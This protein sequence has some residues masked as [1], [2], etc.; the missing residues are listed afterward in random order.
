MIQPRLLKKGDTVAIVAPARKISL[1]E[2]QP[3]IDLLKSWGLK[4]VL[5]KTIGLEHHQFAGTDIDRTLDFQS[6]LDDKNIKAIWCARGGYGT[7][8]IIDQLNFTTFIKHPKWVI[9]YSDI[10][11]LHS[12]IHNLGVKTI[13]ATMPINVLK[14]TI[15]SLKSLKNT[16]FY[17]KMIKN[18]PFSKDNKIGEASGVLVGGNLSIL[19]SLIGST[20]A[21]HTKGKILFIEDVDEYLYHIDRMMIALKRSG[22]LENIKGLIIGGMIQ[23]HDN[24]IPFG[25][26]AEE[27]ILDIVSEYDY[28][29][30]F[31]FPSGH[32]DSHISLILGSEIHLSVKLNKTTLKKTN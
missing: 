8:R 29:V 6:M 4:V 30:C 11:V 26:T 32:I 25:K 14:S 28:P 5:G 27:I 17:A 21:I 13:H 2:I 1:E 20:S 22:L 7:V 19:Y 31:G 12:H 15:N 16:L 24:E 18:A 9:G 10:T 23:M 3:T